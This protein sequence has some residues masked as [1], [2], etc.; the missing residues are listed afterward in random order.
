MT[1]DIAYIATLAIGESISDGFWVKVSSS[2]TLFDDVFKDGEFGLKTTDAKRL[3]NKP[4]SSDAGIETTYSNG[5]SFEDGVLTIPIEDQDIEEQT[6]TF[7]YPC[8]EGGDWNAACS[9]SSYTV[10]FMIHDV[11]NDYGLSFDIVEHYADVTDLISTAHHINLCELTSITH[12]YFWQV[13]NAQKVF[14]GANLDK[15]NVCDY[16]TA[17]VDVE[18]TLT[19]YTNQTGDVLDLS[20]NEVPLSEYRAFGFSESMYNDLLPTM[21]GLEEDGTISAQVALYDEN[22]EIFTA[23]PIGVYTVELALKAIGTRA[24]HCFEVNG[25]L[26]EQ[27]G[28]QW[29]GDECE[30]IT[31]S[32]CGCGIC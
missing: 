5:I 15:G 17:F 12:E 32:D 29:N 3:L 21:F 7:S 22:N 30:D 27:L 13:T 8:N 23:V 6:I 1:F 9:G 16:S 24:G 4:N 18:I 10:T 2:G 19:S 14:L 20:Q 11:C 28:S 26:Y 25:K 31:T